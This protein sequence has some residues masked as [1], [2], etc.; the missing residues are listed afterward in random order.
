V[1]RP[2]VED[3]DDV[4][5]ERLGVARLHKRDEFGEAARVAGIA[6]LREV[7]RGRH[8]APVGG[9]VERGRRAAHARHGF[10]GLGNRRGL[11]GFLRT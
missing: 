1:L 6:P 3:A 4:A 2:V 11:D 7:R 10:G 5:P 9:K 8:D